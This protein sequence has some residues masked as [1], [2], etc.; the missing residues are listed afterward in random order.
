[1][2]KKRGC[3]CAGISGTVQPLYDRTDDHTAFFLFSFSDGKGSGSW[4]RAS[5]HAPEDQVP[6]VGL[7]SMHRRI[8]FPVSGPFPCTGGSGSAGRFLPM[9]RQCPDKRFTGLP[10]PG[11]IIPPC[12]SRGRGR[13]RGYCGSLREALQRERCRDRTWYI[14]LLLWICSS[15][16][17]YWSQSFR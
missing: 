9:P 7:L 17:R 5:F 1:M 14:L 11:S 3:T 6:D 4:C 12:R 13:R 8:R 2:K 16:W 10:G 15:C